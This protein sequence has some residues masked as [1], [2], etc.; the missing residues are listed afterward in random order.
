METKALLKALCDAVGAPG[1]EAAAAA[2]ATEILAPLGPCEISPL[3]SVICRVLPATEGK[4]HLLLDAHLDE[5]ALIVLAVTEDGFLKVG[6]CGGIDRRVISASQLTI[7]AEGGPLKGIVCSVPPHLQ[8]DSHKEKL[9]K[10]QEFSVDIGFSRERAEAL[11]APG[12]RVTVDGPFISLQNDLVA[13]KALDDRA[14]CAVIIKAAEEIK[15]AAPDIGLS[16]V[17]SSMEEVGGMG[18]KTA[19]YTLS[20]THAIAVDVS[21]AHVKGVPEHRTAKIGSG[22]MIG[23]APVLAASVSSALKRVATHCQIPFTMEAMGRSTGTNADDIAVS[24]AGVKTGLV[25]VPQRNMHSPVEVVSIADVENA[26]KLIAKYAT[27][28]LLEETV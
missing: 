5:I 20:P 3:G 23:V 16:V 4:P 19:A 11:V 22:P 17:L 8:D 15:A 13:S 7:H 9:Q 21:F 12:D 2:V 28:A 24:R 10:L 26:A 25:S 27:T 14:G 1:G 6:A 18:A